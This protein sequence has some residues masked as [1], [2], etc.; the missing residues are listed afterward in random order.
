MLDM[1]QRLAALDAELEQERVGKETA[2]QT[3]TLYEHLID[4]AEDMLGAL[5]EA[6]MVRM[7]CKA[8]KKFFAAW[9]WVPCA[10]EHSS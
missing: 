6:R 10:R 4:Y 3:G 8:C 7:A 1:E 5:N 2:E 9:A